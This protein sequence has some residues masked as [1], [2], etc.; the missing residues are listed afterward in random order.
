MTKIKH[1]FNLT[2]EEQAM[3]NTVDWN[4][5]RP[6]SE[7]EIARLKQIA[8]NT[9]AKNKTIT[10]RVSERNLMRL[11]AAAAREGIPYQTFVSSLIQKHT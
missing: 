8:K 11:K 2:T 9:N 10:V 7:K 6:I 5:M 3:H 1:N 4:S